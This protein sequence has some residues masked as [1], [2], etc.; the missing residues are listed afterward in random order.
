MT[1]AATNCPFSLLWTLWND[2]QRQKLSS[3]DLSYRCWPLSEII[4]FFNICHPY[5]NRRIYFWISDKSDLS[6]L[7]NHICIWASPRN[8]LKWNLA[9]ASNLIFS[10]RQSHFSKPI[11]FQLQ[12]ATK[13]NVLFWNFQLSFC[14]KT[15]R[16]I[17]GTYPT[18]NTL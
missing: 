4:Q 2:S 5:K 16:T 7:L 13:S 17:P 6:V 8:F 9:L 14:S 10:P 12:Q 1:R 15:I 18:I 11:Q 3:V